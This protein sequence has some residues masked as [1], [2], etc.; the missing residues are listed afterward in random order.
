MPAITEWV[1]RPMERTSLL[2][3]LDSSTDAPARRGAERA[4]EDQAMTKFERR[5]FFEQLLA[6]RAAYRSAKHPDGTVSID[7]AVALAEALMADETALD[8]AL[9]IERDPAESKARAA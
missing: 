7:E 8:A 2:R 9:G 4:K 6:M 5:I 3:S 1:R